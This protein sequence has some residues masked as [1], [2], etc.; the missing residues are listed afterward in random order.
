MITTKLTLEIDGKEITVEQGTMLIEAAESAGIFIPR[1]CYHKKLS[2]AANCRMCLVEV[3]KSGKPLPACA[4]PVT[5]GLKV[6]TKSPKAIAAQKS[7]MEFLLINHPLDCPVC[8]Q[9]GE[10][11]LQDVS[12]GYGG[13]VSRFS[14]GKRAVHDENLGPLIATEMTRCIHC[15]RCVR[16][17][18]EIAGY[19]E[20][21]ATG[22]GEHM[23]IGT[24]I[25]KNMNSEVSGNVI[26]LCP[27]GALTSKP[28][29]FRARAWELNQR[30][31]ISPHDCLGSNLY[32]HTLRNKQIMRVVPRENEAVNETWISD[33]DRFSY[34]GLYHQERVSEPLIKVK[35]SWEPTTW[36][37]ALEIAAKGLAKVVDTDGAECLAGLIS[38]NSTTEECFLF[39]KLLRGL[40]S[41]NID[42]RIRQCDFSDQNQA[43]LFPEL[44]VAI[45]GIENQN[46]I[47]LVGSHVRHEQPLVSLKI[48]H[49]VKLGAHAMVIN[50]VDY[51]FNFAVDEK[52][53]VAPQLMLN[54]LCAIAKVLLDKIEGKLPAALKTAIEASKVSS[55][56]EAM[57]NLLLEA[58]TSTII[59]GAL[60]FNH[61]QAADLRTVSKVIASVTG[62]TVGC[63]SEGANASGACIAG[64]MPH[65]GPA[66]EKL[67]NPGFTISEILINKPKAFVLFGLEPE[68]DCA[69]PV[70][71]EAILK[72][73]EFVLSISP[74]K[75]AKMLQYSNVILPSV[76]FAETSGTFFN[77]NGVSQS[78]AAVTPPSFDARPGWKVLRVL[79][80]LLNLDGFDYMNSTGVKDELDDLLKDAPHPSEHEN[81]EI[82]FSGEKL[83]EG[84]MRITEWPIYA[85]DNLT[86]RATALQESALACSPCV[87][88]NSSL[89]N[90]YQV[91]DGDTINVKQGDASAVLPVIVDD[92]IP[93]DCVFVPAGNKKS[94]SLG[95][96]F[97]AIE[98]ERV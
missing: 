88:L 52:L 69:N 33:R 83:I 26:D 90:K 79:G 59:F 74:F 41:N 82:V 38:P 78:F 55:Q 14:L 1:F 70:A 53:I 49:A 17:G 68:L 85:A 18:D 97:G 31:S 98:L 7:V 27:V 56:H 58:E 44:G 16:F 6:F 4:T 54:E 80:N 92:K 8:D 96:S 20:L 13:D 84:L 64:A 21:G 81:G 25:E 60:A 89:A 94:A 57:A 95:E 73:A 61:P 36:Q 30:E 39:Q 93:D 86:R 12:M 75:N 51:K 11:E 87:K 23:E 42:H 34:Q 63:L 66:K 91:K 48:R 46:V 77:V 29:R 2:I 3:E 24:Y 22:R 35:G 9:G 19:K 47:L 65:R 76:P 50:P 37:N 72:Q 5:S 15:T 45:N 10:C 28:F 40:G 43:P 32:M 67:K 62:A 71:M